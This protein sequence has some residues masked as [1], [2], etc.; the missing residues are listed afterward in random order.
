M[1]RL[2]VAFVVLAAALSAAIG[3]DTE[4]LR[5]T[6]L[7]EIQIKRG[8]DPLTAE[9]LAE[10]AN[11]G[12]ACVI[13]DAVFTVRFSRPGFNPVDLPCAQPSDEV[14]LEAGSSIKPG[15]AV[16]RILVNVGKVSEGVTDRV[17]ELFNMISRRDK[18]SDLKIVLDGTV[19]V[20]MTGGGQ[21][22]A[23]NPK[24]VRLQ[25]IPEAGKSDALLR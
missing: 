5:F 8:T 3:Q 4:A 14:D 11:Y 13:K 24:E 10:L 21:T 18:S 9:I 15:R 22:M 17:F 1:K 7:K 16:I 25:M 12:P 23:F 19:K 6:A 2:S 20:A